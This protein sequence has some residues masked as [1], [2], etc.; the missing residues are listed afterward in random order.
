MP[1]RY[2]RKRRKVNINGQSVYKFVADLKKEEVI[3]VDKIAE[4]VEKNSGLTKGDLINAFYQ[5]LDIAEIFLLEGHKVDFSPLGSL[6]PS[7]NAIACDTPDEV[8]AKTIRRF[9]PIFK[10]SVSLKKKFKNA[11]F[12]LGDNKI[13]EVSYKGKK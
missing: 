1:V 11:E 6:T 13:R 10:A 2:Y 7:I 8:D 5:M 9:Y 3:K 4:I 12:R